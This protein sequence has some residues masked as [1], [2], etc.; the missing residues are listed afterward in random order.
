MSRII[1]IEYDDLQDEGLDAEVVELGSSDMSSVAYNV[2]R[3]LE[4]EQ[5]I[6]E[7]QEHGNVRYDVSQELT[8]EQQAQ[9]RSNIGISAVSETDP[10]FTAWKNNT[11]PSDLGG[12]V[13]KVPGKGLSSNDYTNE[14]KSKLNN[15]AAGA[16]VNVQADWN[17]SD[18]SSDA[19]IKNKPTIPDVADYFDDAEYDSETKRIN[20]KHGNTVK[21]Y[22]DATNF[23]KDG[24]VS[25]VAISNGC[26][27][28]TFNTDAGLE[29]ISIALTDI[30]NPTNYYDKTGVDT[31]LSGKADKVANP[32][33]GN[34]AS[35][36]ENGNLVDSGHKHSDYLTSETDPTVPAWAKESSKP[37]YTA[38]E[39]G[40]I[41]TTAKGYA[42]GVA[43]LDENGKV[44]S[45]Q[46]YSYV[47]DTI[48]GYLYN[49]G[50]YSD[51]SHTQS[52]TGETGKIYVELTTNKTYRWS[53]S[54]FVEISESLAL[55]ET[56]ST[57][58]AGNK[59]KA[60]A[61]NIAAI[62]GLIPSTA[63][64]SNKLATAS[65]VPS[66]YAGSA[67]ASGP[68]NKAVSIPFG[69]VDSTSTS[70]AFTATVDGITELRDGVCVYL[71]NG[72]VTSADSC[73][74]NVN[75]LGAKPMYNT[76]AATTAISTQWN[77]NYTMLF[78]YNSTRVSGGC[79][80]M[81]YGYYTDLNS[82]GYQLRTNAYTLP[83]SDTSRYYKLF[84]TSA[85]NTQMVP[86][87][88][89]ST[90]D[91]TSARPVNQ[92]PINPFGPIVYTSASTNYTAGSNLAS[93]NTWQQYTFTLGYSF[94]RTGA[95]LTLTAKKPV[96]I[97]C[98]P[99]DDGSAIID[100][101]IP[102]VQDLPTSEDG[103][104]YIF[105]GV[106]YS[107]TQVELQMVHP[108]YHYKNGSINLW[109]G[110]GTQTDV[111]KA[112]SSN[113]IDI[114]E[115]D[116]MKI[117]EVKGKSLVMN[118]IVESFSDNWHANNCTKTLT[119]GVFKIV[120]SAA[121]C[122]V[123]GV[124]NIQAYS[125][126]KYYCSCHIKANS[127]I[128]RYFGFSY[129][130]Q[131]FGDFS[132]LEISSKWNKIALVSNAATNASGYACLIFNNCETT[133]EIYVKNYI[134]I[135]LTQMFGEGKEPTT[136]EEVEAILGDEYNEYNTGEVVGNNVE[137][138]DVYD[139]NDTKKGSLALNLTELT[140][141]VNGEG[142]SVTIFPDGLHGVG[143]VFDSLIVDEDGYARRAVKRMAKVDIGTFT[144]NTTSTESR[145]YA[146]LPADATV[147]TAINN[148]FKNTYSCD[149]YTKSTTLTGM[150]DK[151][152]FLGNSSYMYAQDSSYT[153]ASDFKTA[154]DGV[155]LYYEL[156]TPIEYVL[157]TPV[158]CVV[159]VSKN[160]TVK[161]VP[162]MPDSTPMVMDVTYLRDNALYATK[163]YVKDAI[164]NKADS[165]TT[166]AGY[167]ITDAKIESGVITLGSN[168]ITPITSHQDISSKA[169]K[170]EM[171]VVAGTG[172]DADKTTIT[173]KSGTSA[174]VLT[175]HQD[176]SGKQNAL[177]FDSTP[178][179]NSTNPVTSGGVKT[180]L[181]SMESTISNLQSLYEALT[182]SSLVVVPSADWPLA[183]LSQNTIYRVQG[184]TSYTDYM[185][186][187][188][189]TIPMAEYDNGIDDVPTTGSDNFVK[190]G[191]VKSY[192]DNSR[193]NHSVEVKN[194]DSSDDVS[195]SDE[196]G[197]VIASLYNGHIRTKNFKSEE[198]P[199]GCY[200]N[201]DNDFSISDK[202]GYVIL[203]IHDGHIQTQ[204]FDSQNVQSFGN[205]EVMALGDFVQGSIGTYDVAE[206]SNSIVSD[207]IAI[208]YP[209]ATLYVR[210]KPMYEV[211]VKLGYLNG[212]YGVKF[213]TTLGTFTDRQSFTLPVTTKGI[214]NTTP[215]YL[216]FQIQKVSGGSVVPTEDTG[217]EI[218]YDLDYNIIDANSDILDEIQAKASL[219]ENKNC[220]SIIIHGSDVHG[221][222]ERL[223][224]IYKVADNIDADAVVLTGDLVAH[225]ASD[226][227]RTA[228]DLAKKSPVPTFICAGNHEVGFKHT[229][230]GGSMIDYEV[231]DATVYNYVFK[232]LAEYFEYLS[233]G[234]TVSTAPYYFKD[235]TTKKL[236][237][238]SMYQ[239][240]NGTQ[241]AGQ[242]LS[243][244]RW[245][246][247]YTQ[248]EMDWFCGTLLSTPAEYGVL[249]LI[250]TTE[251]SQNGGMIQDNNLFF[252]D[253]NFASTRSSV[254]NGQP[255]SEIIDAF[256]ARTSL[257]KTYTQKGTPSSF[258]VDADFS[259]IASS[260]N[261]IAQVNGHFHRDAVG[262]VAG[263]TE[264]QVSL[265]IACTAGTYR[266]SKGCDTVRNLKN[267]TGNSFNVY[268]INQ[269]TGK[270]DVFK[271]GA[272]RTVDNRNRVHM[273]I[274]Y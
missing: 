184:T 77:V 170:S 244:L 234:S 31:L 229:P 273:E 68:A 145:F 267:N 196:E 257:V 200:N 203:N 202:N 96:Y 271:I 162:V 45:S 238:I 32:T 227:I 195:I 211:T 121:R 256:I 14:E 113:V 199:Q 24:M 97:K 173:L 85:D 27:V 22:I 72:I 166:L 4:I 185:Y 48:E 98:R 168:T 189:N 19:Y 78:I 164:A 143:D 110:T 58:Y 106:A 237:I 138:L 174:T 241:D 53:G 172:N 230:S 156:A 54:G 136:V 74:L 6:A 161:Q 7:L 258:S 69:Q 76:M 16:E 119:D 222:F 114:G 188:T 137:K 61:E 180:V 17:E 147:Y 270:I 248:E 165:A 250:H 112:E 118:Q 43:E 125:S 49:G 233:A 82:V 111:S 90:N 93:S 130:N 50:W 52:V 10:V 260:V 221:D 191:G 187:G 66:T 115:Y 60:N 181:D 40:A 269:T 65:D 124:N 73:T 259:S 57:A 159:P 63:T 135:D 274:E 263:T 12:K 228:I 99:L 64:T 246:I 224:N 13:D 251:L 120:P 142:T 116:L 75:G 1:S 91:A 80:D 226:N 95:A 186:D 240:M 131:G 198:S 146:S 102:Y 41:P 167:G 261:F 155:M 169:N 197:N 154:M 153:T 268:V 33:T 262:L 204:K 23:V 183:S 103:K 21:A 231:S 37:S 101:N 208:P 190:S 59:G 206:S 239:Y 194:S 247:H 86:A 3:I 151:T 104:I 265:G 235:L 214:T 132:N 89:N 134:V 117:N 171:S 218:L 148:V 160:G 70:T 8:S 94:N 209:E 210:I 2:N 207:T 123:Y 255:L 249:L 34:F 105:L 56:S 223:K 139:S 225:H 192:I 220:Y 25:S 158:Q 144:W 150:T 126:H 177:T 18:S 127:S 9:A 236:R 55:G 163:E 122:Y 92:R 87:S 201:S 51:S 44:P 243:S 242:G 42:N 140:G 79:W 219:V 133:D 38:S 129:Y 81:Y 182:Q 213:D 26:L 11:Y 108:V 141:K 109:T 217:I 215:S 29:P 35:L 178:T 83:V 84:F 253:Y 67:T 175:A 46:M 266:Q 39:V 71:R 100:A 252:T 216:R 28:V 62:Q 232:D 264:R 107:A 245:D 15:I 128:T 179:A 47:D 157:D 36:D 20:F 212:D 88:V 205:K 272:H 149:K 152:T 5:E 193:K 30:F 254:T 176:I